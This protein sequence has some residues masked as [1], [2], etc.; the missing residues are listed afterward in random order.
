MVL[1]KA[2]ISYTVLPREDHCIEPRDALLSDGHVIL[3]EAQDEIRSCL[4]SLFRI[5]LE[6]KNL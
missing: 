5:K 6:L 1:F 3:S 4:I 2:S